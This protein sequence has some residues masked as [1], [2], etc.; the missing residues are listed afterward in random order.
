MTIASCWCI[1]YTCMTITHIDGNLNWD[2]GAGTVPAAGDY[3][4][5]TG[6]CKNI[7]MRTL[8]AL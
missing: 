6:S 3:I 5:V 4:M 1:D 8:V 7:V 2:T